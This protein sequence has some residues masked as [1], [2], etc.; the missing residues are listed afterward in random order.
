MAQAKKTEQQ[1]IEEE[2]ID[3]GDEEEEIHLPG[4]PQFPCLSEDV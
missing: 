3:I 4:Q 2:L 1:E